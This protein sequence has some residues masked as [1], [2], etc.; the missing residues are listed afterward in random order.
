MMQDKERFH[1]ISKNWIGRNIKVS[2]R[3][4]ADN[5]LI[6]LNKALSKLS[7][8][9]LQL[10]SIIIVFWI[11]GTL[12]AWT[13]RNS[14]S[15]RIGHD[16]TCAWVWV[17]CGILQISTGHF[18][19]FA[20][21]SFI[22]SFPLLSLFSFLVFALYQPSVAAERVEKGG[23]AKFSL[24]FLFMYFFFSFSSFFLLSVL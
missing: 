6:E 22:F 3:K 23:S 2:M 17:M 7:V 21:S 12:D 9:D 24:L 4:H 19:I 15:T 18:V 5:H 13:L 10:Q 20:S 1:I 16:T 11:S 8:L 14:K